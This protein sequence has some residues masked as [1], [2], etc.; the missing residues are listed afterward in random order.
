M[1]AVTQRPAARPAPATSTS[2][3]PGWRPLRTPLLAWFASRVVVVAAIAFANALRGEGQSVVDAL[4]LW[5]GNWYLD[6]AAGYDLPDP[7]A[8]DVGKRNIAFFPLYPL[9]IRA[10]A[11]ITGGSLL[12]AGIIVA[13]VAGALALVAIWMLVA[14]LAGPATADRSVWLVA[15]FPASVVLTMIYAEGVMLAAAA[16]ALLALH[17]RRWVTAGIFG[18]LA[19]AARPNGIAV[20]AACGVAALLA[21]HHRRVWRALAAPV[22]AS[23]GIAGYFAWLW[24]ATGVPN[25][26]FRVQREGWGETLDFGRTTWLLISRWVPRL[27]SDLASGPPGVALRLG[28]LLVIVV[29]AVLLWRW[30]PPITLSVYSAAVLVLP[31]A[32]RTLGARP[33]FVMVAFPLIAAIAWAV[34]GPWHWVLVTTFGSLLALTAALYS[35]PQLVVP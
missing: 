35:V 18:A 29:G 16:A 20:V 30:R 11:A 12:A 8:V 31:L 24:A 6:A 28:G 2:W 15:F 32:S 3:F 9:L 5:D 25:A 13:A 22:I 19:S 23:L 4:H 1:T 17:E 7:S 33:R 26:W 34:K 10:V 14:R 21:I 27:V